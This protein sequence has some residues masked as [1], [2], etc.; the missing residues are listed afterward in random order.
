MK[1]TVEL[2]NSFKEQTESTYEHLTE[3]NTETND[4]LSILHKAASI[5]RNKVLKTEKLD[6]EYFSATEITIEAQKQFLDPILIRF[7]GWLSSNSKL[8]AAS[9]TFDSGD[10]DIDQR[11]TAIASDITALIANVVTPKH[12]GLTVHL[13]HT[14]GSKK[15]IEDLA[16]LGHT[17]SYSEL[18][19][20]LTS[21]AIHMSSSQIKT[22]SG[23]IV[24]Q[25][26][27]LNPEDKTLIVAAGDNWD[28]NEHTYSGKKSTHAMTSIL[29]APKSEMSHTLRIP[30]VQE[31]SIDMSV[32]TGKHYK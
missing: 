15:L 32:L 17:V 9:D 3:L 24:P 31:R 26:L 12:L 2:E 10:T 22:P 4:E 19:H 21:A 13:H 14:F 16:V 5:L 28:H 18:R 27:Q 1:R 20:F 30:R 8:N 25:H 29:V 7:V 11:T 23:G 6:K